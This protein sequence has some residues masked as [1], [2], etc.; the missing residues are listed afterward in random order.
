MKIP[1]PILLRLLCGFLLS[2]AYSVLCLAGPPPIDPMKSVMWEIMHKTVLHSEKVVFDD[3]VLVDLPRQVEDGHQVPVTVNA[4]AVGAVSEI[5][6]FAD[7]NPIPRAIRFEPLHVKPWL[8]TTIKVNQATPIRAAAR[9]KNG[10][11]HINGHWIDAPGGGCALPSSSRSQT[12]WNTM[13]GHMQGR[14]WQEENGG[15]LRFRV[16]IMH[17]MDT[18]LV[19]QVPQFN[20]QTLQIW[21]D[22]GQSI[23]RL[24]VEAS[25][26]E[27]PI[28]T[29]RKAPSSLNGL[30]VEGQDTDGNLYQA[31][32]PLL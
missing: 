3:A 1:S 8:A 5:L 30:R 17:P 23:A 29:L 28:F 27:N 20:L 15:G 24:T 6:I 32:L 11:W 16:R 22:Q 18:G 25:V 21:D 19:S 14:I 4:E 2:G 10:V 26:A 31:R 12:D 9:D 13:L 7:Y